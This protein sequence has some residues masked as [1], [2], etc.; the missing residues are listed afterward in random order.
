MSTALD[1]FR[2]RDLVYVDTVG[3]SQRGGEDLADLRRFVEAARPDEVHLVLSAPTGVR[4]QL[5]VVERFRVLKPN[6]LLFTKLDETASPGS[7]ARVA[8][9]TGIPIS[10]LTTG[11]TVPDD[12]LP[13]DAGMLAEL[14]L[15]GA[16]PHA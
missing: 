1:G 13:A 4:T 6:R 11:Q 15:T 12:I 8:R 9:A 3:R 2:E 16:L 10:Y 5:E 14:I 7:L